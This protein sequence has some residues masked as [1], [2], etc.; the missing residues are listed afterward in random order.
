MQSNPLDTGTCRYLLGLL[1]SSVFQD[2]ATLPILAQFLTGPEN[3]T[4]SSQSLPR[5]SAGMLRSPH[6]LSSL[7]NVL[8]QCLM[9]E[10]E[11]VPGDQATVHSQSV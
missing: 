10:W 7:W 2:K 8:A 3:L 1:P 5:G 6:V 9:E 11:E 4:L